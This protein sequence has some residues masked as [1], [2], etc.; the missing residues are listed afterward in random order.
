MEDW[1]RLR[2]EGLGR[3]P[4][5]ERAR[6]EDWKGSKGALAE[7]SEGARVTGLAGTGV[8]GSGRPQGE[9]PLETQEEE[10]R[11]LGWKEGALAGG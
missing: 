5:E 4:V 2:E 10:G 1:G 9:G 6:V 8:A 11:V 7:G 3:H